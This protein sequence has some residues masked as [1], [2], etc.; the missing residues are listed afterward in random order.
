MIDTSNL[1]W[2]IPTGVLCLI[3]IYLTNKGKGNLI[4]SILYLVPV[5]TASISAI[6]LYKKLSNRDFGINPAFFTCLISVL[7]LLVM[8]WIKEATKTK[9]F[10]G[11]ISDSWRRKYFIGYC[12]SPACKRKDPIKIR[13]GKNENGSNLRVYCPDCKY[14]VRGK[15]YN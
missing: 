8:S 7:V 10:D 1:F 13:L 15:I 2:Q 9:L 3:L 11:I 5:V 14:E 4:F 6:I 12:N